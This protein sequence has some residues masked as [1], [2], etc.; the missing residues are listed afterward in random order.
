M[1]SALP[2]QAKPSHGAVVSVLLFAAYCAKEICQLHINLSFEVFCLH[3]RKCER[4]YSGGL[5][6]KS[7]LKVYS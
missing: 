2:A 5:T 7:Q 1:P 3:C 4:L 6:A